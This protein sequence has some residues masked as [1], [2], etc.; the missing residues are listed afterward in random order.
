MGKNKSKQDQKNPK[1]DNNP[2]KE[3]PPE[4]NTRRN[5]PKDGKTNTSKSSSSIFQKV[6]SFIKKRGK[7]ATDSGDSM[8]KLQ[9]KE[10][11]LKLL[12]SF[13]KTKSIAKVEEIITSGIPNHPG[14]QQNPQNS[15]K[16][17]GAIGEEQNHVRS[18][19]RADNVPKSIS[20]NVTFD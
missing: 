8:E 6:G 11:M 2:S 9:M 1:K 4:E 3:P 20:D 7:K 12:G 5:S 15:K 13:Y 17:E 16:E 18:P 14:S 10:N 19:L